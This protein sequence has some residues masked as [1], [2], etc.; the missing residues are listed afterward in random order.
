MAWVGSP[1][2]EFPHVMGI[3]KKKKK[4]K[5][6]K[7]KNPVFNTPN[8]IFKLI[9]VPAFG[10]ECINSISHF[11]LGRRLSRIETSSLGQALISSPFGRNKEP[12]LLWISQHVKAD[13]PK[14]LNSAHGHSLCVHVPRLAQCEPWLMSLQASCLLVEDHSGVSP[15]AH[16]INC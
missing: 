13:V 11:D 4:K 3:A 1:A 6:R 14:L 15:K 10:H 16:D 7:G 8:R 12:L 5:K 2:W 9:V